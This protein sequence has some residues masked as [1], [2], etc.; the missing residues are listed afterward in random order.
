M[1]SPDDRVVLREQL[2]P[3]PGAELEAAVATTFTLD[4]TAA[5]VAPLAFA[6]HTASQSTDPV[7]VLESVRSVADKI[8]VF[9][10]VGQIKVPRQASDLMAFLEPMVHEVEAPLPGFLFHPKIWLVRYRL[11]DGESSFRLL[12]GTRNLTDDVSWDALVR[13]DGRPSGGRSRRSNAPIVDLLSALPE[14]AV[15]GLLEDRRTRLDE[16]VDDVR[17]VEWDLPDGIKELGFHVLGLRRTRARAPHLD[18]LEGHRHLVISPFL[19]DAGVAAAA[20]GSSETTL[21]ARPEALDRLAP[22]TLAGL[23]TRVISPLA[24]LHQP[25]DT[26]SE[27]D[28][29]STVAEPA[30]SSLLGGLHAKVYVVESG[31]QV[32]MLVGSANATQAGLLNGNVEFVVEMLGTRAAIGIDHFLGPDADFVTILER[33]RT[34]GGLA[35][36]PDETIGRELERILRRFAARPF[37]A[38]VTPSAMAWIERVTSPGIAD[39]PADV[40]LR[41]GLLTRQGNVI[42]HHTGPVDA[43]FDDLPTADITPFVVLTARVRRQGFDVH[44]AAVIRAQLRNDPPHRLDE[45]IARQVDTPEKFL[46]FVALLLG[47]GSDLFV[48]A[49]DGTGGSSGLVFGRISATGLFEQLVRAAAENPAAIKSLAGLVERLESTEQG[50][51]IL[52]E[53]FF[54]LWT[55]V[56]RTSE[57]ASARS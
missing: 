54:K 8:D 47:L 33:Y 52:P 7:A 28:R 3:E 27:L 30:Q 10:Q 2:R 17:R 44:R 40:E 35:E 18:A 55:T 39:L 22:T 46:R 49:G 45:V 48:S 16:L 11:A 14:M 5:L 1:L 12:C 4:L 53:G 25:D 13:L 6:A 36:P 23:D 29:S 24:G 42:L 32:R 50:R 21:V 15:R 26:S 9:C 34:D 56:R 57:R 37:V 51:S 19:D 20:A 43:T 38:T 41:I 31:R